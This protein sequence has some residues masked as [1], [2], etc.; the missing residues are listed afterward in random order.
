MQGGIVRFGF[1]RL[2]VVQLAGKQKSAPLN[3]IEPILAR[4]RNVSHFDDLLKSTEELS[5]ERLA[6]ELATDLWVVATINQWQTSLPLIYGCD[7]PFRDSRGNRGIEE[8]TIRF[9]SL[10]PVHLKSQLGI[11]NWPSLWL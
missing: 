3:R 8:L 7:Y 1:R 5:K 4:N 9:K 11:K 2:V 10:L 6:N